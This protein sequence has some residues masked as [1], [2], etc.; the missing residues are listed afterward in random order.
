MPI[1]NY[2]CRSCENETTYKLKIN[3]HKNPTKNPC[4][5]CGGEIF[6]VI[7]TSN[8][9]GGIASKDTRPEW[10]KDKLRR[11]KKNSGKENQLGNVI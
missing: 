3:E 4:S 5:E 8:I 7:G 10:F 6:Q 2:K 11:L 1:Y 9:V